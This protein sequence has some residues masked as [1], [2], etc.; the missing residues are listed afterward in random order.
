MGYLSSQ[1]AS[2][3][4]LKY[5]VNRHGAQIEMVL[6]AAE[7]P[8]LSHLCSATLSSKIRHSRELARGQVGCASVG[9]LVLNRKALDQHF[10]NYP[11]LFQTSVVS[12]WEKAAKGLRVP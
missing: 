2:S 10:G 5:A 7:K 9:V 12:L 8:K 6:L 1:A 11:G 4:Y 3:P